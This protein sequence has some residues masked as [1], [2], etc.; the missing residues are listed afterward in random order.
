MNTSSYM[1]MNGYFQDNYRNQANRVQQEVA[2]I[3]KELA[4]NNIELLTKFL[5]YRNE[6][7]VNKEEIVDFD[8]HSHHVKREDDI[9]SYTLV[10]EMQKE[11]AELDPSKIILKLC[12][13][14]FKGSHKFNSQE[15]G[16]KKHRVVYFL[17]NNKPLYMF[18]FECANNKIANRATA[19]QAIGFLFP[20][21][22]HKM[23]YDLFINC[24]QFDLR[25]FENSQSSVKKEEVRDKKNNN[26]Y[27]KLF[28]CEITKIERYDKTNE[29][30]GFK[31]SGKKKDLDQSFNKKVE[32]R[33]FSTLAN[34][35]LQKYAGRSLNFEVKLNKKV[36]ASNSLEG[37]GKNQYMV[38]SSDN[39][40]AKYFSIIVECQNKM[41][42]KAICG[43]KFIELHAEE[44][45]R[46]I[47]EEIMKSMPYPDSNTTSMDTSSQID[48]S[49]FFSDQN[50]YEEL[51]KPLDSAPPGLPRANASFGGGADNESRGS[52]FM[53]S[54][55]GMLVSSDHYIGGSSFHINSLNKPLFRNDH[56]ETLSTV[57]EVKLAKKPLRT[58]MPA[59]NP[60]YDDHPDT[61]LR[62]DSE[63]EKEDSM[64]QSMDG[65]QY[66]KQ[67]DV[68]LDEPDT[69]HKFEENDDSRQGASGKSVQVENKGSYQF[70]SAFTGTKEQEKAKDTRAIGK[71]VNKQVKESDDSDD[72]SKDEL[73]KDSDIEDSNK[74]DSKSDEGSQ[75]KSSQNN[76]ESKGEGYSDTID[77]IFE[78]YIRIHFQFQGQMDTSSF[79]K[80]LRLGSVGKWRGVSLIQS[81]FASSINQIL[82]DNNVRICQYPLARA[83]NSCKLR[84]VLETSSSTTEDFKCIAFSDFLINSP[85]MRFELAYNYGMYLVLNKSFPELA[86]AVRSKTIRDALGLELSEQRSNLLSNSFTGS[87]SNFTLNGRDD[88]SNMSLFVQPPQQQFMQ[89]GLVDTLKSD[90]FMSS[91]K[92]SQP[93]QLMNDGISEFRPTTT[94]SHNVK[95][96]SESPVNSYSE[97]FGAKSFIKHV[98]L[99]ATKK[100][101]V[102]KMENTPLGDEIK[103]WKAFNVNFDDFFGPKLKTMECWELHAVYIHKD[104]DQ[105]RSIN[106]NFENRIKRKEQFYSNIIKNLMDEDYASVANALIHTI[107][108]EPMSISPEG[109]YTIFSL[110]DKR[111]IIIEARVQNTK[112]R[113][114]LASMVILGLLWKEF[115]DR[116]TTGDLVKKDA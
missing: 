100:I 99:Y 103:N 89:H 28:D 20:G 44:V 38:T 95:T 110:S 21:I 48:S 23:V 65:L 84:F 14:C 57:Q 17:L 94:V 4:N 72:D 12:Q 113:K 90:D 49:N 25:A 30:A 88:D 112:L 115:Y 8:L 61:L 79:P 106:N 96:M 67:I 13:V 116:C 15:Q 24:D 73:S 53:N 6:F 93:M 109:P 58:N 83:D 104:L 75:G 80:L 9:E 27:L 77:S 76:S 63:G 85:K 22:Y 101:T 26:I 29:M 114:K 36:A 92:S 33:M 81:H 50:D 32:S 71:N 111:L 10:E 45:F 35:M 78:E 74:N 40:A 98:E 7:K 47:W 105:K 56:N 91:V 1:S 16:N 97:D 86:S 68:L 34:T 11:S 102:E 19:Y 3:K 41:D 66:K 18:K 52:S 42:A 59:F 107:Y 60:G 43:L 2:Q 51:K 46:V 70:F 39:Q 54:Q 82:S 64:Y 55:I 62:V 31:A 69:N 37:D 5:H 87:R 108:K